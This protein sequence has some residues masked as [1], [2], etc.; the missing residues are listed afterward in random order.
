MRLFENAHDVLC[1]S[2]GIGGALVLAKILNEVGDREFSNVV[3][4]NIRSGTHTSGSGP[5]GSLE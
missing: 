1:R 3:D 5:V 2:G 4:I